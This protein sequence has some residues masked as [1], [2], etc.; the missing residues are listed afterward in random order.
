[1]IQTQ[2]SETTSV[3]INIRAKARQRDLIDQAAECLGR[4]RSDFMLEAAC[5]EAEDVLLDQAFFTVDEGTFAQFQA[6]LDQPLP[7]T[8]K[9][10]RLLKA[11]APWEQ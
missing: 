5:R 9:L 10:R 1:M 2:T 6:L 4:S 11:K 7:P 3:S 8:D